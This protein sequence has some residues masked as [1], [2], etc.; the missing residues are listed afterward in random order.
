[1]AGRNIKQETALERARTKL[2]ALCSRREISSGQARTKLLRWLEA[3]TSG[4]EKVVDELVREKYIDDSRFAR[5]YTRDKLR[6]S[7]WGPEKIL[8]GLG[9]AGVERS[10]AEE[11]VNS[12]ENLSLEV[13]SEL[14]SKK[15]KELERKA[16]KKDA[17]LRLKLEGLQRELEELESPGDSADVKEYYKRKA[18]LQRKIYAIQMKLRTSSLQTKEALNAYASSKGFPSRL[19]A[20]LGKLC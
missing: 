4:A 5:A 6:F 19:T 11:A 20:A 10:I 14:L 18:S 9:D 16:E 8:R 1:M 17:G 15:R 3:D 7:K 13:L 12:E 2:M